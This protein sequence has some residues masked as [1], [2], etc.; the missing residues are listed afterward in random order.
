MAM[1][2]TELEDRLGELEGVLEEIRDLAGGALE[3][4]PEDSD[5]ESGEDEED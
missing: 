2:R 5:E 1:T 4:D 3:E